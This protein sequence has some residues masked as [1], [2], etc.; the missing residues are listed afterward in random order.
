MLMKNVIIL[1]MLLCP[2]LAFAQ[3]SIRFDGEAHDF[4][5]VAQGNIEH[6]FEFENAGTEDLE[7]GPL[8]PS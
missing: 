4:G 7:I 5:V 8:K 3:P 6:V 1:I 2:S